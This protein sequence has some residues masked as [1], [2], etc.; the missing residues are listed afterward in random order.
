MSAIDLLERIRT[1]TRWSFPADLTAITIFSLVTITAVVLPLSNGTLVQFVLGLLFLL[2]VPGYA[3]IAVLFPEAHTPSENYDRDEG[4]R[5]TDRSLFRWVRSRQG[6]DGIERVGLAF[7]TSIAIVPLIGIV[8]SFT[9]WGISLLP[10]V[11]ACGGVA[12]GGAVA[13]AYR[14]HQLPE[15]RRVSVPYRRWLTVGRRRVFGADSRIDTLLTVVLVFSVV[16]AFG[17]VTFAVASPPDGEQFSTLSILTENESGELVADDYPEELTAGEAEP[18][19]VGIENNEGTETTYTVIVEIHD[20]R[21]LE[22]N[23]VE[24]QDR[25]RVTTLESTLEDGETVQTEHDLL[26]T[27]TGQE[28]RVTYMLYSDAPPADPTPENADHTLHFWVDITDPNTTD[29]S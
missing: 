17:S 18:I 4:E 8:L 6:I 11:V 5:E 14:R 3:F 15:H 29:T 16:M 26:S 20:V 10:T 13:A 7:G 9:P 2:F 19:V 27:T 23:Q 1:A 12:V 22:D 28:R 25:E 21:F 24:V